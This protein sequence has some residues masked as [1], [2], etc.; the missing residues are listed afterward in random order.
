VIVTATP[1]PEV[2]AT[3][4]PVPKTPVSGAF[5]IVG[6]GAVGVGILLLLVGLLL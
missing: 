6:G 1:G 3:P 5:P 4:I 2:T